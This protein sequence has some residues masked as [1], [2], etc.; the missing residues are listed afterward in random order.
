MNNTFIADSKE[1][2]IKDE[3]TAV[4]INRSYLKF[5]RA[6]IGII[7]LWFGLLKFFRGYSPAEDLAIN[8]IN[9]LSFNLI[10]TPANIILLAGWETLIG[11]LLIS[12]LGVR[13]A[14]V[15][16]F[17][18]I[19]CTFTPLVFFPDLS[20]KYSPYGFTLL[21]QYIMKNVVIL[22]AAILLW[23]E[24]PYIRAEQAVNN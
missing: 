11:I 13:I 6:S 22:C 5:L 4:S 15:S 17:I 9:V 23:Q 20:F 3:Q 14:W 12:G 10:P 2:M 18:H 8:T 24:K 21:G 1:N 19:G 16:V 7:Y